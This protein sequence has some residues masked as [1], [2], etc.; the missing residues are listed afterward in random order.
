M[1]YSPFCRILR[2]IVGLTP[3]KCS[4]SFACLQSV[5]GNV[6]LSN[7]SAHFGSESDLQTQHLIDK[8]ENSK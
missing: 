6:E 7:G 8:P 3:G 1:I 5:I 2:H 4:K